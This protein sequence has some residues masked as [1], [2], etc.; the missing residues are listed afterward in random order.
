MKVLNFGSVNIDITYK[1]KDFVRAGET[2]SSYA[3]ERHAGGK[4]FNQSIAMARAGLTVYHAGCIGSDGIFLREELDKA[5]VDTRYLKLG[6]TPTGNAIIQVNNE[7][8]NCI[9][10]YAGANYSITEAYID[11]VLNDFEQGD[12]LVV[13][14]EISCM[15]Y[16]VNTAH[17]KGMKIAIN[18]SPMNE[19]INHSML[20]KA[21]W[22]L[23][24]ELEAAEIAAF[25]EEQRSIGALADMFP[26]ALIVMTLGS[27]GVLYKDKEQVLHQGIYS[28]AAVDTTGAGDT[29]TGYFL[30][31]VLKGCSHKQAL[32]VASK[33]AAIS[34]TKPGAAESIPTME[35]VLAF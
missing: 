17:E 9:I 35:Q 8:N 33:A 14:N 25:E 30:A 21:T 15:E 11:Q 18:P 27:E 4:G 31:S 3:V 7:G 1:V 20:A 2:I 16:L 12:V 6:E 29:F 5:G 28:V 19:S 26:E 13:Q 32:D 23:V 22:L 34:V 24:N 10:L